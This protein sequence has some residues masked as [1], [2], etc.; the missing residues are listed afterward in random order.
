MS[1]RMAAILALALLLAGCGA[2]GPPQRPEPEEKPL[3]PGL[4]LIVTG[5]VG[6]GVRGG[7]TDVDFN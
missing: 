6:V 1:G 2:D 5:R 3:E 7:Y 4:N